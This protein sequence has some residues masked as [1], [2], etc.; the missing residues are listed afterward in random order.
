MSLKDIYVFQKLDL[1]LIKLTFLYFGRKEIF[2]KLVENPAN[3]FNIKLTLIFDI[4][5]NIIYIYTNKN[6]K[7]CY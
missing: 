5:Q 6:I 7:F 4:N 2:P 1:I 3:E